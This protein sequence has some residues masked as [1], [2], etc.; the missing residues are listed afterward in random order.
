[1]LKYVQVFVNNKLN[2][3]LNENKEVSFSKK[4]WTIELCLSIQMCKREILA[5]CAKNADCTCAHST[6]IKFNV[7]DTF[8]RVS[9]FFLFFVLAPLHGKLK[10][11]KLDSRWEFPLDYSLRWIWSR[12]WSERMRDTGENHATKAS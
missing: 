2:D 7:V 5:V 1:M 9:V 10:H 12:K 11:G 6:K 8:I 3:G 4:S